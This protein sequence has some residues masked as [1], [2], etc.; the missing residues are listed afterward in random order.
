MDKS[1]IRR[2]LSGQASA[3]EIEQVQ[4][5]LD[6]PGPDHHLEEILKEAWNQKGNVPRDNERN[7]RLLAQINSSIQKNTQRT[8]QNESFFNRALIRSAATWILL[9]G[10]AFLGFQVMN[11]NQSKPGEE[12]RTVRWV[13][14]RVLPGQKLVLELP[15]DSKVWVNAHS[16]IRF[17]EKFDR[18]SREVFLEG[19]AFFEV[20]Y[21][22]NRPFR[23]H[24][25]ALT[26]EV[27]G[28]KF[29]IKSEE[30]KTD[31][32]LLEGRVR[33]KINKEK[34]E[35]LV[36]DPGQLA[37]Y[38]QENPEK[39]HLATFESQDPF[40]W[41]DGLIHFRNENFKNIME[42]LENWYGISIETR[43]NLD[44]NRTVSGTFANDNLE[45]MLIGLG[46]TLDFTHSLENNV[47]T[48][49]PL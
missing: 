3:S 5:W 44:L 8:F 14:R 45:N 34:E 4:N 29:N 7:E 48:I 31:V 10:L 37:A 16:K 1:I 38:R 47:V 42:S 27:L 24:S 25:G 23:V 12:S 41:K 19:E 46:F 2:F 15:D 32:A 11:E 18:A 39:L 13:E 22:A 40:L 21:D 20:S 6:R 17:P 49:Y 28:T 9:I 36:L 30:K 35:M 26:T 43:G 33:V